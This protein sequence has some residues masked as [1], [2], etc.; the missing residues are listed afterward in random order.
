MHVLDGCEE[1]EVLALHLGAVEAAIE[2]ALVKLAAAE[3][4]SVA[5]TWEYLVGCR[6]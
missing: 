6:R 3:G 2:A 1:P 4:S 5:F